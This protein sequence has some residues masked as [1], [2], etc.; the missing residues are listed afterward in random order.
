[1][2]AALI[3]HSNPFISPDPSGARVCAPANDNW[4]ALAAN[5]NNLATS[6]TQAPRMIR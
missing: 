3:K 4:P 2:N 6:V 5:D 1:M